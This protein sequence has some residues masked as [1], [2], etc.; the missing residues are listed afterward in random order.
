[1]RVPGGGLAVPGPQARGG[2]AGQARQVRQGHGRGPAPKRLE[3]IR[4]Y[5][6][7]ILHVLGH[8]KSRKMLK[9]GNSGQE[10]TSA[11]TSFLFQKLFF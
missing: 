9:V 8:L 7:S 4:I 2:T 3:L 5:F 6:D 1:M 10:G 11:K